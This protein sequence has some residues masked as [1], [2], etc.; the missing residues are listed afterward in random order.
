MDNEF[1]IR[2]IESSMYIEEIIRENNKYYKYSEVFNDDGE[3]NS[4]KE[5]ISPKDVYTILNYR[6][7]FC[8]NQLKYEPD[9][10]IDQRDLNTVINEI[11]YIEKHFGITDYTRSKKVKLN[12]SGKLNVKFIEKDLKDY[13]AGQREFYYFNIEDCDIIELINRVS[14]FLYHKNYESQWI[15]LGESGVEPYYQEWEVLS[16]EYTSSNLEIIK[17]LNNIGTVFMSYKN[18]NVKDE[19]V[20]DDIRMQIN[21]KENEMYI[22]ES[23]LNKEL[24]AEFMN[25]LI[26]TICN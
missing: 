23:M 6:R 1:Y 24:F 18:N 8:E 22:S 21:I 4:I 12:L 9:T 2:V 17:T 3:S 15:S 5:E 14:E 16:F 13:G 19:D 25:E 11:H 20:E 26:E 10:D 7:K